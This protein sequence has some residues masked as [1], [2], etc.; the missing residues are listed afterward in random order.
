M[1]REEASKLRFS[2]ILETTRIQEEHRR[3][4][5]AEEPQAPRTTTAVP[6]KRAIGRPTD[7]SKAGLAAGQQALRWQAAATPTEDTMEE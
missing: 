3:N 2:L 5:N 7:I 6:A 1:V 4:Q